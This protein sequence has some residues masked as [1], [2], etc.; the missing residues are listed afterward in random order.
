MDEKK[1]AGHRYCRK[2]LE[3]DAIRVTRDNVE[4]LKRFA[5]GKMAIPRGVGML[6]S[7]IAKGK[8]NT[9]IVIPEGWFLLRKDD[10]ELDK[11][12]PFTFYAT[13]E[14]KDGNI[15]YLNNKYGTNIEDRFGKMT[16]E[17]GELREAITELKDRDSTIDEL[18]DLNV[19]IYHIA[20]ILGYTQDDLLDIA[21]DKIKGREFDQ[22]YKRKHPHQ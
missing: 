6:A 4:E 11:C 2:L 21:L 12:D 17:F 20:G 5:D 15:I 3:I 13:Y 16:E 8:N 18:A 14:S 10:G 1:R 22:G 7:Y 9:H 19:I